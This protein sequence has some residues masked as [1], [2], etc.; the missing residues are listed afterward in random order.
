M[1]VLGLYKLT[2]TWPQGRQGVIWW[3]GSTHPFVLFDPVLEHYE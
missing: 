1:S 2:G 3:E